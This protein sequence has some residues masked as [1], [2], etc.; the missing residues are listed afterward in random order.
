MY[1]YEARTSDDL[2]FHKGER[3]QIMINNDDDWW[4]ARSLT[5]G[6]DGYIPSNYVAPYQSYQ[7]EA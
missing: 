4:K 7:A 6:L 2:S 5:T 1:D 3:L